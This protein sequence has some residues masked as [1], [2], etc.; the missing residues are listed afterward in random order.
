[1]THFFPPIK[2]NSMK[3]MDEPINMSHP[4]FLFQKNLHNH[5]KYSRSVRFF[6]NGCFFEVTVKAFIVIKSAY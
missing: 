2:S 6:L 5:S 1:M 4:D 3:K